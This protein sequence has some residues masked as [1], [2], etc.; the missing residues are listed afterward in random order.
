MMLSSIHTH[1]FFYVT[2]PNSARTAQVNP[3]EYLNERQTNKM[4]FRPDMIL[5]FAHYLASSIPHLGP[6]PLKVEARMFVSLNGRKPELFVDP[7]VDLAAEPRSL[8]H[9]R[10]LLPMHEPL[11]PRGTD[12]SNDPF[13]RQIDRE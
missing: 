9:A 13:A 10:W 4:G 7:N 2:D 5:Q 1:A 12:F 3:R 8:K 6:K 11:P